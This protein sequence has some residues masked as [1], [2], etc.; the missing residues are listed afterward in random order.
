MKKFDKIFKKKLANLLIDAGLINE[1]IAEH[2]RSLS[3]RTGDL[4][5]ETLVQEGYVTE[6]DIARELSRHLQLPFLELQNYQSSKDAA[7]S[8]PPELL[9][10]HQIVPVDRFGDTMS[11]AMSQHL[12]LDGFKEIQAKAG[13]DITFFVALISK[14]AE[15]LQ[16]FAPMDA[17]EIRNLRKKEVSAPKPSSWTDIFDTANKTVI[18]KIAPEKEAEEKA[19][20][21]AEEAKSGGALDLFDAANKTVIKKM[22]NGKKPEEKKDQGN[23]DMFDTANSKIM[24]DENEKNE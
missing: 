7:D 20:K 15:A 9:Q 6:T 4:I 23:L 2:V 3:E 1:E 11:L 8:L 24:K 16:E 17:E 5:G 19:G 14:V 21:P 22:G 18:K 10:R 13:C 12:T